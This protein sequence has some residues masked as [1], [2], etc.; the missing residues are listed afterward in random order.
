MV[1]V[2][3]FKYRHFV[4]AA[5]FLGIGIYPYLHG[6]FKLFNIFFILIAVG[7]LFRL[8]IARKLALVVYVILTFMIVFVFFPPFTSGE[9]FPF[10]DFSQGGRVLLMIGFELLVLLQMLLLKK[11]YPPRTKVGNE[12]K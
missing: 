5:A 6:E 3:R 1:S 11:P 10:N 4:V 2:S 8:N 12:I 7:N 9:Y